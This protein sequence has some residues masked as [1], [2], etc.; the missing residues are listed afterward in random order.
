MYQG[1]PRM[2]RPAP[3]MVESTTVTD[4]MTEDETRA[5]L[6][7]NADKTEQESRPAAESLEALRRGS[8]AV[9]GRAR[10]RSP[11]A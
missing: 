7:A 11:G 3:W 1:R 6:R 4:Y 8:T 9:P 2:A 10:N 5:V